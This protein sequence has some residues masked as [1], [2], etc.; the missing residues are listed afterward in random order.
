[1][2]HAKIGDLDTAL[3][4]LERAV[5]LDYQRDL[6]TLEPAFEGLRGEERFKRLIEN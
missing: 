4:A 5:E 3:S 1:L 6:L 2:I